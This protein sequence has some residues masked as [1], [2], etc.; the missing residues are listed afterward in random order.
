MLELKNITYRVQ[1][2][3]GEKTILEDINLSLNERFVAFTF[4]L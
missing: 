2:D 3:Q 4:S 1:D